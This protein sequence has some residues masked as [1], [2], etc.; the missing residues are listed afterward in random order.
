MVRG[1]D[2]KDGP[3]ERG[4]YAWSGDGNWLAQGDNVAL[5]NLRTDKEPG[6]FTAHL[7]PVKA[8][9]LSHDGQT[10]ATLGEENQLHVWNLASW[11]PKNRVIA[12]AKQPMKLAPSTD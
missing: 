3:R 12:K 6:Y 4:P 8:L 5:W 1:V 9:T 7:G 10:L 11:Q 2:L